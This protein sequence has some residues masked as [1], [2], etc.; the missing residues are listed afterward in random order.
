MAEIEITLEREHAKHLLAELN[1]L[2][3]FAFNVRELN[4]T[5]LSKFAQDVQDLI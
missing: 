5:L 2:R 3:G 4:F 1:F